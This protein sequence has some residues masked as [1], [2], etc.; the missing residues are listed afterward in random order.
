MHESVFDTSSYASLTAPTQ[1]AR[2]S[3]WIL[4]ESDP[5]RRR[6]IFERVSEY[7]EIGRDEGAAMATG[8]GHSG[9]TVAPTVF[10]GVSQ[11]MRIVREEIFGPVVVVQSFR[12]DAEA[13][14]LANDSR[15]GRNDFTRDLARAHEAAA[16]LKSGNVS[17]NGLYVRDLREPFGGFK[18]SRMGRAGVVVQL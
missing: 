4:R 12:D 6:N 9:W 2:A 1:G 5:C 15:D 16:A 17:V 10:T 18:D 3:P 7:L 11:E 14:S 13:F 8:G